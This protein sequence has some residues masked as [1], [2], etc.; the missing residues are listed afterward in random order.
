MMPL[1]WTLAVLCALLSIAVAI[2]AA[3]L[4]RARR[5]AK[6]FAA[7]LAEVT[8][9]NGNR[10]LLARPGDALAPAIYAAN[11]AVA[12]YERRLAEL[13]RREAS[14]Q[15][16]M[17]SLSHDV[18]TPLTSLIGYL[19]TLERR[20]AGELSAEG[21]AYVATAAARARDLKRYTDELFEYCRLEAGEFPLAP[22]PLDVAE[23]VR[24]ILAG[25]VVRFEEAGVELA[26]D[27][28]EGACRAIADPRA[29]ERVVS[30]LLGNALEHAY[31]RRVAV[32]VRRAGGGWVSVRVADGEFPRR[33]FFHRRGRASSRSRFSSMDRG[34]A[35]QAAGDAGGALGAS[36]M[37]CGRRGSCR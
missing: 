16:V 24:R 11:E 29:L 5:Q 26:A 14:G 15:R 34:R 18:R 23:E 31:A 32:S 12:S 28:P 21:A 25:W 36:G 8:A 33:I 30:N 10:R 35:T 4:H 22:E 7:A 20:F 19:D 9:G 3:R 37:R 17:A 1:A 2:L 27:I 6:D 13:A